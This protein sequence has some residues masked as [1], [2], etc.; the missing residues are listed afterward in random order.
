MTEAERILELSRQD[1]SRILEQKK[2]EYEQKRYEEERV[3]E[4]QR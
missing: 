3:L 2:Y 1:A 4:L